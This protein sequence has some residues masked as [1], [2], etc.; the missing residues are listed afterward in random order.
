[1]KKYY[2][3]LSKEKKK[4]IKELYKKEYGS[5]D[6]Q[7]RLVRLKIYAILGYLF[8]IVMLAYS[9]KFEDNKIGTIIIAITLI[10]VSTV[11]VIGSIIVKRRLLNKLALKNK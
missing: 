8:S 9:F 3:R 1:M 2:S 11:Y 7:T 5:S 10:C 6:V 4:N